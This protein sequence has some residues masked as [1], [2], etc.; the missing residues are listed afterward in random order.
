MG[1]A[2]DCRQPG[3]EIFGMPAYAQLE[4]LDPI[5]LMSQNSQCD[6]E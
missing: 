5:L 3:R 6:F 1:V 2:W 4:Q